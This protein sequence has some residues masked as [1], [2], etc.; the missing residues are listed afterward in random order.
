MKAHDLLFAVPGQTPVKWRRGRGRL[1][2]AGLAAVCWPP[3]ILTLAIWPPLNW[4]P[5]LDLDWRL[6]MLVIGAVA[7]PL[8]LRQVRLQRERTGRPATRLGIVW[9]FM[10]YGGLLAV[11]LQTLFALVM[12]IWGLIGS[13]SVFQAIGS[14][15]TRLLL[16]GVM[17]LPAAAVVGVSY[18]LWAGLCVALIAFEPEPHIPDRLNML[19]SKGRA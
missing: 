3:L 12:V 9:R 7:M 13:G 14:T 11:A 17:M 4:V 6:L 2:L 16:Y 18:A 8:G 1:W 10:F 5:G 15:E 19:G